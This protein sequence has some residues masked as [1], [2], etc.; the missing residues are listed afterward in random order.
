M[1]DEIL[2][3]IPALFPHDDYC[4]GEWI[5]RFVLVPSPTAVCKEPVGKNPITKVLYLTLPTTT[6]T[7]GRSGWHFLPALWRLRSCPEK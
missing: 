5:C 1:G 3:L 7:A 4:T 6:L 2:S